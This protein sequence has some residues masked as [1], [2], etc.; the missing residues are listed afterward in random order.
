MNS[1]LPEPCP[2]TVC[3]LFETLRLLKKNNITP[4]EIWYHPSTNN[5]HYFP[6]QLV[7]FETG[8]ISEK[9]GRAWQGHWDDG[10]S[11]V[12][13]LPTDGTGKQAQWARS[14]TCEKR[15]LGECCNV[16][17]EHIMDGLIQK[18]N[19]ALGPWD[20]IGILTRKNMELDHLDCGGV[21]IENQQI[22]YGWPLGWLPRRLLEE[23]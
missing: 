23:R 1:G 7:T 11:W 13:G 3:A 22:S 15:P 21:V 20:G 12:F 14:S 10:P 4:N 9:S 18:R 8:H 19:F 2:V 16:S 5:T 17:D 6:C